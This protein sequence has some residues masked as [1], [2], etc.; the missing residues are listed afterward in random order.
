MNFFTLGVDQ[1]KNDKIT[2]VFSLML[3]AGLDLSATQNLFISVG[4]IPSGYSAL[5]AFNPEI[6]SPPNAISVNSKGQ[7][8][9]PAGSA[10][11]KVSVRYP[12]LLK[13]TTVTIAGQIATVTAQISAPGLAGLG[14]ETEGLSAKP[15]ILTPRLQVSA[16]LGGVSYEVIGGVGVRYSVAANGNSGSFSRS[17]KQ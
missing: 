9:V 3:P 12:A 7:C 4:N 6:L 11:T 14:L 5:S 13:S 2:L 8:T 10:Y 1:P 15:A 17:K 16:V